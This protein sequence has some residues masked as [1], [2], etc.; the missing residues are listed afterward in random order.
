MDL[1]RINSIFDA[2]D[3]NKSGTIDADGYAFFNVGYAFHDDVEV[4]DCNC[5]IWAWDDSAARLLKQAKEPPGAGAMPV[6]KKMKWSLNTG[7]A[8]GFV[9]FHLTV[10]DKKTRNESLSAKLVVKL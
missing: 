8:K 5:P 7:D 4:D 6:G 3:T 2:I 1:D 9:Q 10:A